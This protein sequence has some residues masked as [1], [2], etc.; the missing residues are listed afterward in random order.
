MAKSTRACPRNSIIQDL[1]LAS[2]NARGMV[3]YTTDIE[4]LRPADPAK[5]NRILLFDVINR[6]N[7][8]VQPLFN[9]DVPPNVADNNALAIAGDGWLQRQGYT[10]VWF[11]WQADVLP[12]GGRMTLSVPVARNPDGSP[13]TG[14]RPR[15]TRSRLAPTT[16]LNAVQRL[17]H[18][19]DPCAP[20]PPSASTTAPRWPTASCRH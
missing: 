2:R 16:T 20:I 9:A 10:L 8:V 4:I 13:L 1:G 15:R 19:R 6:G 17:V 12:G 18:R 7:K 3:E 5:S 11:G 14:T